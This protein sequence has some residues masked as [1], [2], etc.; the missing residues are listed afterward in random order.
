MNLLQAPA[1][2][3]NYMVLGYA[4]ILG[5][6]FLYILSFMVRLRNMKRDYKMLQDV[7]VEQDETS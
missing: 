3:F 1:E 6:L 4:V 2:T 5:V 7:E